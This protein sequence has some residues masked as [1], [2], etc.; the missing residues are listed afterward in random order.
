MAGTQKWLEGFVWRG[1]PPWGTDAPAYHVAIGR[2]IEEDDGSRE[3]LSDLTLTPAQAE[4]AGFSLSVIGAEIN[5]AALAE[6]DAAAADAATARQERDTAVAERDAL[7]A[8]LASLKAPA[9][10]NTVTRTQFIKALVAHGD[11]TG[12]EG[13][14]MLARGE[15]PA[16]LEAVV[17]ALPK[18]AE[19]D[20][21][22]DL[23]GRATF[24][25]NYLLVAQ[26][27]AALGYDD[28]A[29]DAL[30]TAAAAL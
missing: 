1:R 22:M 29:L 30:W 8:E 27:G 10:P 20:A 17:A 11:I 5:T 2:A 24:D 25:R 18:A 6:R 23:A 28:K 21:R 3:R 19:I 12:D 14:A 7:A 15:L 13:L 4:A 26:L 16:R 9:A